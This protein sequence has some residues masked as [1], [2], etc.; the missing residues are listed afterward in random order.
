MRSNSPFAFASASPSHAWAAMPV[1]IVP[2]SVT[3]PA[4]MTPGRAQSGAAWAHAENMST[5]RRIHVLGRRALTPRSGRSWLFTPGSR[6]CEMRLLFFPVS[7]R[8]CIFNLQSVLAD[9]FEVL[10]AELVCLDQIGPV[11]QL[12]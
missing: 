12:A 10:R 7:F 3:N 9:Q 8:T 5:L 1:E 4:Q 11:C 2:E 6:E